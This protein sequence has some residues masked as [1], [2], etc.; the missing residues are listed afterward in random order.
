MRA[1]CGTPSVLDVRFSGLGANQEAA[2][3]EPASL[4]LLGAGLAGLL[5]A[6]RRR[7]AHFFSR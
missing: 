4:A 2:V 5:A 1:P 7:G 6:R 3:A